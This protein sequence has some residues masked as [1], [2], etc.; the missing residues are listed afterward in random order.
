MTAGLGSQVQPQVSRGRR[1]L[2]TGL[3]AFVLTWPPTFVILT[4]ATFAAPSLTDDA[5]VG[6]VALWALLIAVLF[7]I[8]AAVS[9][10]W[11]RPD[12]D[13]EEPTSLVVTL[14]VVRGALLTGVGAGAVLA[15]QGLS[16]RQAATLAL[17]L[18]LVLRVLPVVVART[19]RRRHDRPAES[20][21]VPSP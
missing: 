17:I 14:R 6:R 13:G 2:Q 15:W 11:S 5:G 10:L 1:A 21:A 12:R 8:T 16:V 9:T 19:L 7:A 3:A 4:A 20:P 18:A